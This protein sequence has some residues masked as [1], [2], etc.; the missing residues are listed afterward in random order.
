[1]EEKETSH[2]ERIRA[3]KGDSP[4]RD[5]TVAEINAILNAVK[6]APTHFLEFLEF[7]IQPELHTM[8]AAEPARLQQLMSHALAGAILDDN[9]DNPL[10]RNRTILQERFFRAEE[11]FPALCMQYGIPL[12]NSETADIFIDA[13][14]ELHEQVSATRPVEGINRPPVSTSYLQ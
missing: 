13:F 1:M 3:E 7:K 5:F 4:D 11:N 9:A 8:L 12:G 10:P 2:A 6:Y 14:R